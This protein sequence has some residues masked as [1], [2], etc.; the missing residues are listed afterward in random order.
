MMINEITREAGAHR[1]RKRVGRGESSG[2]GKTCTRGHKGCQSRSG[3]GVRPLTEGGQMPVFRRLPKRG[4]SNDFFRVPRETISLFDLERV[5]A[6][7]ETVD[8]AALLRTGL[9]RRKKAAVKVLANGE[10][11]KKLTVEV[12]AFSSKARE[13][14]EK[15][16]GT[17][18]ELGLPTAGEKAKAKRGTKKREKPSQPVAAPAAPPA[19]EPPAAESPAAAEPP[20]ADVP[21][22]AEE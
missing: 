22:K 4:F 21:E 13:A 11:T 8:L 20:A 15:A 6:E 19:A 10:L 16:G 2:W 5:F 7:G 17:A 1:A 9:I 14:I 12:H 3:G 18:K